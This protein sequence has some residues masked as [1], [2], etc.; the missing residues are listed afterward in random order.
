VRGRDSV[1]VTIS[2]VVPGAVARSIRVGRPIGVAAISIA[3]YDDPT[4][5]Y[6]VSD[7]ASLVKVSSV[8]TAA[9]ESSVFG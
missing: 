2:T 3:I 1:P 6:P 9:P 8:E 5:H 7:R 4:H